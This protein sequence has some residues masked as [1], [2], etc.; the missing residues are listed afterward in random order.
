MRV[1]AAAAGLAAVCAAAAAWHGPAPAVA[2]PRCADPGQEIAEV[3][4]HQRMLAPERIWPFARGNQLVVA[5]LDTGVDARHPQLGDRVLAGFDAVRNSGTGNTD[6]LGTGTQVAGV[7][8]AQQTRGIGFVGMA[9]NARILPVKVLPD[10]GATD[11]IAQPQ[12]LARGITAAV[13]RGARVIVCSVVTYTDSPALEAA[14][15]GA[16][17]KGAV[18]VAAV[19]D[20]GNRDDGGPTPYPAA[21]DGVVGVGAIGQQG[22]RWPNSQIGG[23]VDVVAP[24][25]DVVTLQRASG[26][27]TVRGGTG[28]AAGFVG[29]AAALTRVRRPNLDPAA[30]RYVLQATA[31]GGT[32]P[33]EYGQGVINP[34]AAVTDQITAVSPAPL[35][36]AERPSIEESPTW[37]RSRNLALIGAGAAVLVV[38]IV[39]A[40]AVALPR[41]RRRFW[42]PAVAASPVDRPEDDEPAPPAL[43]FD[44]RTQGR[45]PY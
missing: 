35:P 9:P 44:Q 45:A 32:N 7:I 5:V 3:P 27:T 4:W 36:A 19:G 12:I 11:R 34:Y 39:L 10:E 20:E 42:R 29:A 21:Y 33:N 43:L 22:V 26:M 17:Q 14:V 41:G 6:C 8:A 24:G 28:V 16:V 37:L 13:D 25:A 40:V 1:R 23:Y 38:L 30:V 31:I 2:A 18:I 15:A